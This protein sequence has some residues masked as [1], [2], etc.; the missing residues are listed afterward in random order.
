MKNKRNEEQRKVIKGKSETCTERG[1]FEMDE[2]SLL[3][4]HHHHHHHFPSNQIIQE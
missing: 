1:Y 4:L 3:T 2:P